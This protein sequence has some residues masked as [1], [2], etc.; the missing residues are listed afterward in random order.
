LI[1]LYVP[2]PF[3]P[4]FLFSFLQLPLRSVSSV[5]TVLIELEKEVEESS[6][7][8]PFPL[9]TLY[10][11]FFVEGISRRVGGSRSQV[12]SSLSFF[13]PPSPFFSIPFSSVAADA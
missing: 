2:S 1:A 12:S 13:S 4:F 10:P 11:A 6:L 7:F 8:F 5:Q 9:P 3:S